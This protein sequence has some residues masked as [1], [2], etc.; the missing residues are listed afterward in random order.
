[1]NDHEFLDA[2]AVAIIMPGPVVVT[3]AFI[4]FLV[5]GFAGSVMA[6]A[7]SCRFIYLPSFRAL[8]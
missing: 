6:A 4:G 5:A 2:V 7:Y 3:V 1:L 8:V